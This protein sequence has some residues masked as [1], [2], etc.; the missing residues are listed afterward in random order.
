MAQTLHVS[1]AGWL[2]GRRLVLDGKSVEFEVAG[3]CSPFCTSC[4]DRMAQADRRMRLAG[5]S[6][7]YHW[8]SRD[9]REACFLVLEDPGWEPH[10]VI[11]RLGD[12]LG[13][14]IS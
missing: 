13:L 3:Q 14:Q 6:V 2:T 10:E 7:K 8:T 4:N 12:L 11:P 9:L 1:I 5:D